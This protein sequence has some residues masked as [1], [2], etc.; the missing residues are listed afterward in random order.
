MQNKN[1]RYKFSKMFSI[2]AVLGNSPVAAWFGSPISST[3][4]FQMGNGS[5]WV[6]S[7]LNVHRGKWREKI[8]E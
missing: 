6:Q 3:N 8:W 2:V 4:S 1:K 5:K 7:E